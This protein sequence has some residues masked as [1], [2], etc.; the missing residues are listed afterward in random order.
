VLLN[1]IS[2]DYS[3]RPPGVD[4]IGKDVMRAS[5]RKLR[6][7][8]VH[9]K[10]SSF[11]LGVAFPEKVKRHTASVLTAF[12]LPSSIGEEARLDYPHKRPT[13]IY[14]QHSS[15]LKTLE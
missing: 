8:R 15:T 1:G 5:Q 12:W 9:G 4:S 2:L 13:K 6:A 10:A 14:F 11:V 3:N 7:F